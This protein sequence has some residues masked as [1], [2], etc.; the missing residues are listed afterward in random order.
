MT[1]SNYT[2]RFRVTLKVSKIIIPTISISKNILEC[3]PV[4]LMEPNKVK[5][6]TLEELKQHP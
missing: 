2:S 3:Y 5:T 6:L 4:T 1:A